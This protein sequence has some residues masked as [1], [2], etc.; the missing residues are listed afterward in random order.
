MQGAFFRNMGGNDLSDTYKI[1]F[2]GYKKLGELAHQV[3]EHLNYSDTTIIL[4]ECSIETL[5]QAVNEAI[6]EGCQVFV[7]G[8]ANAEEFKRRFYE[9]LIELHI[10][11]SDYLYCLQRAK[12]LGAK[13]IAVTVHRKSRKVDFDVLQSLTKIPIHTIYYQSETELEYNLSHTD[14]DCVIGAALANEIAERL[15][16]KGILIY[17]GEYTIRSSIDQARNLAAELQS[18]SRKE[19]ITNAIIRNVPAGIIITDENG[20]ITT[21]NKQAKK[22]TGF[23]EQKLRGQFL[24]DVIPSLSY[25]AFYKSGQIQSDRKH[26]FDGAMVR[27]IQTRLLQGDQQIGMLTTLQADNSRRKKMDSTREFFAH[28]QWKDVL[29]TSSVIRRVVAEGKTMAEMEDPV[30]LIGENG[31][32]KSFFAQCIHNG[33]PRPKSHILS[34]TPGPLPSRMPP[35]YCSAVMTVPSPGWAFLSWPGGGTIAL[36]GLGDASEAFFSCLRQV[37]LQH[38]YFAVGGV[39]TIPFSARL[40]ALVT[41]EERRRFPRD[42]WDQLSVFSLN[43]PLLKDRQED[44]STLFRFFLLRESILMPPRTQKELEEILSFYSWPANL[45]SLSAVSKRYILLYQQAMNP[46][47]SAKQQILI[48]AIGEDELL[49]DIY[50]QYPALTDAANSPPE[51]VLA[52]VAA[53][54]RILKYNNS[55]IADKLG[56]GRTTLW[57]IQKKAG[58]SDAGEDTDSPEPIE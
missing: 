43:L 36:Q 7:A 58:V 37:L 48:R 33:S 26:L 15:G 2:L 28:H 50:R 3:I 12:E 1:C 10:D 39:T 4:K 11:M 20:R 29:G 9:H 18:A 44:V 49:S 55:V 32:G 45:I 6:S 27:C 24:S 30:A 53:M 31:T 34:S 42:L 46:S 35:G 8:S 22:L 52:G 19:S 40:L 14:C 54:K 5:V 17:E 13:K 38:S 41:P 56:L 23:Q 21:F 47:P 57:R 51:E 16:L 25:A